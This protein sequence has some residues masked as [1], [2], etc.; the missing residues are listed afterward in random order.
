[1]DVSPVA[2]PGFVSPIYLSSAPILKLL[3]YIMSCIL[4][5]FS[6]T[7][8]SLIPA[9][10]SY[11]EFRALHKEAALSIQRYKYRAHGN[12]HNRMSPKDEMKTPGCICKDS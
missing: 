7:I 12:G 10:F 4:C 2:W 6:V 9:S 3:L 1:M 8:C 5:C 11:C